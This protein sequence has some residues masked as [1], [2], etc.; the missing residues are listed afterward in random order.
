MMNADSYLQLVTLLDHLFCRADQVHHKQP[1][2]DVIF[3]IVVGMR[4]E[5]DLRTA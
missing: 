2:N 1:L 5:D 4:F 3:G